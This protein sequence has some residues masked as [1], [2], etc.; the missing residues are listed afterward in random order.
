MAGINSSIVPGK[1]AVVPSKSAVIASKFFVIPVNRVVN[2]AKFRLAETKC[3][4][5]TTNFA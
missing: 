2:S 1:S 4:V 3:Q 5:A